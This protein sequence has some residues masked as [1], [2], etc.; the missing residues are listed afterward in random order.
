[1]GTGEGREGGLNYLNI[2]LI[3]VQMNILSLLIQVLPRGGG[4]KLFDIFSVHD[5]FS[6]IEKWSYHSIIHCEVSLCDLL[7]V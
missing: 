4:G 3:L 7:T 6:Y 2:L 1:M 5:L